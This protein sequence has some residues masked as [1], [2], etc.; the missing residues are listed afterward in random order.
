MCRQA[1]PPQDDAAASPCI[2]QDLLAETEDT[3]ITML[4]RSNPNF[5]WLAS[6]H[7]FPGLDRAGEHLRVHRVRK[8][9]DL[10]HGLQGASDLVAHKRTC[11]KRSTDAS[12]LPPRH[13]TCLL[14][15]IAHIH[16]AQTRL[17]RG[18]AQRGSSP[19]RSPEA[20]LARSCTCWLSCSSSGSSHSKSMLKTWTSLIQTHLL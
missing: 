1:L 2:M 17:S 11:K 19:G 5:V 3:S 10:R 4:A 7:G 20:P 8:D 9:A 16:R 18:C 14:I 15:S 6:F 12:E 13:V